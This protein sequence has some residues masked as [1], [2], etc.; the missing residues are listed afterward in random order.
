MDDFRDHFVI[1]DGSRRTPLLPELECVE[2]RDPAKLG[3]ALLGQK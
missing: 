2:G 3:P 1:G